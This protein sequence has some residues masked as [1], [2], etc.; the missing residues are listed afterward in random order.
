MKKFNRK[1]IEM[2]INFEIMFTIFLCGSSTEYLLNKI[3][4]KYI[5][6]D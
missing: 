6:I 2:L 5:A 4:S 3:I 1:V